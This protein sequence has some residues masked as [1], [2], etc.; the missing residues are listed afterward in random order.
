MIPDTLDINFF[1]RRNKV[2]NYLHFDKKKSNKKIFEY[3]S[4]KEEIA[5]HSF[6]P[7]I[8]YSLKEKKLVKKIK[9]LFILMVN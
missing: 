3:V 2:R 7:T 5:I 9:K 4:N 8:S 1:E 6:F